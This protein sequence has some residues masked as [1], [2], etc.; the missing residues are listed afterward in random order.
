MISALFGTIIF[1]RNNIIVLFTQSGVGYEVHVSA[2]FFVELKNGQEVTVYT[3]LKV[4]ENAMELFGF[5]TLEEKEFFE[6]LISVNGVGPR[7]AMN[8]MGL[9]SLEHIQSAIGRGDVAYL[10]GVSGIG[11]K[12]AERI[13]VDLKSKIREQ[14]TG[15]RE[16]AS[17]VLGEV[18]EALVNM[19]YSREEARRVVNNLDSEGKDAGVLLRESLKLL[20]K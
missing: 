2:P 4:S 20:S 3:Y 12:T 6:L 15:N 1:Q 11:K 17:G 18:V 16:Q 9:G 13:V 14:G 10:T 7:T 8:I 19:G 5:K